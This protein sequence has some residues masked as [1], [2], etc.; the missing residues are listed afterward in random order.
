MKYKIFSLVRSS[1]NALL[2]A[3][4]AKFDV[5]DKQLLQGR[6]TGINVSLSLSF[7]RY[8]FISPTNES[9]LQ[10]AP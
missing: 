9:L 6:H 10:A 5:S 7:Y 8:Q 4:L 3:S 2:N 1:S